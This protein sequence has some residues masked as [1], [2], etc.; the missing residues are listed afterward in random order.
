[1]TRGRLI[2]HAWAEE[3]YEVV[4]V[5][6]DAP[7]RVCPHL[8]KVPRTVVVDDGVQQVS[9]YLAEVAL[10]SELVSDGEEELLGDE[11]DAFDQQVR[12]EQVDL[13][14]VLEV[15]DSDSAVRG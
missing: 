11:T 1:M 5:D 10:V 14:I 8:E 15:P 4:F 12:L 2:S 13:L 3:L 6:A 9:V 7:G